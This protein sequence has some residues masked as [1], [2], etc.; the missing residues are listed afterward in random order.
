M[1]GTAGEKHPV[2]YPPS[3]GKVALLEALNSIHSGQATIISNAGLAR[4]IDAV[5]TKGVD[6]RFKRQRDGELAYLWRNA[7]CRSKIILSPRNQL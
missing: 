5:V 6:K 3:Q 1:T 2:W 4:V 7:K